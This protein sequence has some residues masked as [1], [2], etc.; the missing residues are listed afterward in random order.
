MESGAPKALYRAGWRKDDI[1][2]GDTVK[3]DA[4]FAKDGSHTTAARQVKL[5]DGRTAFAGAA[6]DAPK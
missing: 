2:V 4:F 5:A 6:P 1:Q 3:F